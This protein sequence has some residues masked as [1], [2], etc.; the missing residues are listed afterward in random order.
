M[1]EFKKT[2]DSCLFIF[3]FSIN[4]YSMH[5]QRTLIKNLFYD[6]ENLAQMFLSE[7]RKCN[8]SQTNATYK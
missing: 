3:I 8:F 1:K 2:F 5:C 4:Y 6:S 7:H